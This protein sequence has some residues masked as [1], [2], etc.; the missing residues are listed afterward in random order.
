MSSEKQ[1]DTLS[2][3]IKKCIVDIQIE[4]HEKSIEHPSDVI[5]GWGPTQKRVV[6]YL[7]LMYCVAPFSNSHFVFSSPSKV[8][9][10]CVDTDPLTN[11]SVYLKNSCKIGNYTDA[12]KCQKFEHDR[13]Y[14]MRTLVNNFDLVC[15]KAWYPSFSESLHQLG[16]A[17]SGVVF[18]IISD[19]RGRFFAAKIAIVLE[20]VAGFGQAFAPS[21]YFYWFSR[22][23][24]GI[25]AYGRFLNGYILISEWVGPTLRG[26][27]TSSVY[28]IGM[29]VGGFL[30]LGSYYFYPD[31]IAIEVTIR[32]IEIILFIGYIFV[33]KESPRWLLSHGKWDEAGKLL[34]EAALETAKFP[35]EEIDRRIQALKEYT[36]RE[37]EKVKKAQ[38]EKASI[39]DI[40]KDPQLLKTSLIF[41]FSWFTFAFINYASGLNIGQMGGS[42]YAIVLF[43]KLTQIPNMIFMY[44]IIGRFE[45]K[46]LGRT[47]LTVM[48]V[49][50]FASVLCSF[51]PALLIPLIVFARIYKIG[52]SISYKTLY[53]M[54]AEF[55]PTNMRQTSMGI[56]SIF[57]RIGSIIAP[58][59]KELTIATALW[60][61]FAIFTAL[62]VITATL[63]LFLPETMDVQLP[64]TLIQ[65]KNIEAEGEIARSRRA[66]RV[67]RAASRAASRRA[68]KI[69]QL[70]VKA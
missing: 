70:S 16:Y 28:E 45:R 15:D 48:G 2:V 46:A 63:W 5:G 9:F 68:S 59:I 57:A 39:F 14:H 18:G 58:F 41:Y 64:D 37:Q 55:F 36:L 6:F 22:F 29:L 42:V 31:Y 20:I 3:D 67:S 24:V 56:C 12:P 4:E 30:M 19:A 62:T 69:S 7:I 60:V 17:V 66:S 10:Y 8:D 33:V 32:I 25:A 51:S 54:S 34:K 61:P 44:W 38:V 35:E 53:V 50:L 21:I 43:G 49:C 52:T 1:R 23:F 65:S 27:L 40:W 47:A 13:S 26:K 11:T